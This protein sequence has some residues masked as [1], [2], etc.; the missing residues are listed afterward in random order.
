MR[1]T[2][3][4][5]H[6]LPDPPVAM[7]SAPGHQDT[8]WS[9][10]KGSVAHS[11]MI[12]WAGGVAAT[13]AIDKVSGA[14]EV[15]TRSVE[16]HFSWNAGV[17]EAEA[18]SGKRVWAYKNRPRYGLIL[19]PGTNVEFR[20]KEKSNYRFLAMEFEPAYLLRAAELQHLNSVEFFEAWEHEHPLTWHLAEAIFAE[21]ESEARQGL[22]YSEA[23]ATL[24]ALHVVRNLSNQVRPTN[25]V[26][27]GGMAPAILRRVCDYMIS[28]LG[29]DISLSE[30]AAIGGLSVGHFAFAFKQSTGISP[31]GWLRRRRIDV[32]KA[33][34]RRR[35]LS[36]ST[37]AASIGFANQS[38]FGVAFRKETGLTPSAWRRL[39]WS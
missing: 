22:L 29:D 8:V 23:A 17:A 25:L 12:R 16:L 20:I 15:R 39:H 37:I 7:F 9:D 14:A 2:D 31:H 28:R 21:C 32:A 34:L 13:H 24:L 6:A 5:P 1:P 30:L 36:L 27:R 26:S 3:P 18:E 19:P 38:A 11:R 33:L 10:V 4:V 35:D